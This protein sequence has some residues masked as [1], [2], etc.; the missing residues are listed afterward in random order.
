MRQCASCETSK[1]LITM[2]SQVG[3]D[4]VM[5]CIYN[6]AKKQLHQKILLACGHPLP[7]LSQKLVQFRSHANLNS[8]NT[9]KILNSK[10]IH[11][12]KVNALTIKDLLELSYSRRTF[13]IG[14]DKVGKCD[15]KWV[16]CTFSVNI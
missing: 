7:H 1:E 16:C 2:V 4:S 15:G 14:N 3:Y 10:V 11:P 8:C 12:I 13:W 9:L 5:E 6:N